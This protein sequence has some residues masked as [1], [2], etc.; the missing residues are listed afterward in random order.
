[1][2]FSRWS[3][4]G[5][6]TAAA[7]LALST[8]AGGQGPPPPT[9]ANGNPVTTVASGVA[10]PTSFAFDA[11]TSTLF[12]GAFGD[13]GTGEG[14]GVFTATPDGAAVPV[15]GISGSVAGLVDHEGTLYVSLLTGNKGK[16]LALSG[17]NGASFSS[18]KTIFKSSRN[19]VGAVNGLAWG[20][21]DR[22]YGGAGLA[23]DVGKN[24]RAKKSPFRH[25]YTVFS[26]RPNGRG[27]KVISRGLRQPWQMT[28]VGK[29]PH[30]YVSVLS[31]DAG[32][33]PDDAIVA[34]RP[35]ANYGFPK[36]FAGVGVDCK[37]PFAKP[38]IR[39]PRHASPMGIQAVGRTLYVALFGGIGK[40]GPEVV[41]IP[42]KKGG[43]PTP[44][45]AG[46]AAPVVALGIFDGM[47][48]AGDLT[49][50]I[51]RVAL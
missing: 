21:D 48:Y 32:K 1:M 18:S 11:A 8:A 38:L 33:I 30:P 44:F 34:A 23:V 2:T 4:S 19:T 39:L 5:L 17:W 15:P 10:T 45:L 9:A 31:Q 40:S 16:V 20:P 41:T 46:F 37:H 6:L 13:E 43:K 36:C 42:A 7:A 14:G 50:S 51:Y 22:L 28:F 27:F 26:I 49:G 24:G 35:G 3:L 25:P 47:L 29:A 12:I